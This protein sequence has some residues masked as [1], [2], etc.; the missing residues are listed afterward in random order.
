MKHSKTGYFPHVIFI[1]F[2]FLL[3]GN[4]LTY[5]YTLDDFIVIKQNAFTTQGLAGI[6]DIFS[7]DSFTGFFGKEKKLVAGGRYRPLSIATFAIEY[8]VFGKLNP[9][10]SHF[11]N[12]LLYGLT[13]SLIFILLNKILPTEQKRPWFFSAPFVVALLFLAHPVHSEV[14][15][16][17]K[18][19][20]ELLALLLSL[21]TTWLAIRYVEEKRTSILPIISLGIFFALLAKE[22]AMAFVLLIPIMIF[23]FFK[24]YKKAILPLS[25]ALLAGGLIFLLLRFK[26][27]GYLSGGELPAELLNN[28]FLE[29][30]LS[31]KFGT[32]FFTL[33]DYLRLLI[34]PLTLT[35]D[36]Y[37][38][39]VQ[40]VEMTS[41]LPLMSFIVYLGMVVAIGAL[42][43]KQPA[44]VFALLLYLVPLFIVSNLLFS[45][46]TFMNERFIYFSSLGFILLVIYIIWYKIPVGKSAQVRFDKG[47]VLFVLTVLVLFSARTILR[48]QVWQSNFTLFTSDVSVSKNS[49]KCNVAAGGEW[50]AFADKQSSEQLK[51]DAYQKAITYLER[52]L[53]IHPKATNG[54]I[55]LGN[56]LAKYRKDYKG[57]ISHYMQVLG[58]DANDQNAV[59]NVFIVL[60]SLDNA[61]ELNYKISICR[62][63]IEANPLNSEAYSTVGKLY[64]Q[65]KSNF[66]SA[67]FYLEKAKALDPGN[68]EISKDLGTAY[69]MNGNYQQALRCFLDARKLAPNDP[70]VVN[71]IMV[72]ERL[73]KS[74]KQTSGN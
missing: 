22:N 66:D 8:Q 33:G 43:K 19:R 24:N 27:L 23:L 32:I 37:P 74:K 38:Y 58:Y 65:Y 29:S 34:F 60:G 5:D 54:H 20:D 55:L 18:G 61:K 35:H 39:H 47:T 40:L 36:Y 53:A 12:I 42:L 4:T 7:Y 14:V 2:A 63:L 45:V 73:L 16:N 70:S 10:L 59:R 49:V 57:A 64:G 25:V 48:N 9:G 1:L 50:M 71:N 26:V 6:P 41:F 72:T 52:S 68:P 51:A 67:L 17:I 46:G 30:S 15:A 56:A 3:Y 21:W 13:A 69:G 31:Q 44:V 62:Q 11:L 28:P